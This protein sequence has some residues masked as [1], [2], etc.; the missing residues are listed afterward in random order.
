MRVSGWKSATASTASILFLAILLSAAPAPP[1]PQAAQAATHEVAL[2]LDAASSREERKN[3]EDFEE[4][5]LAGRQGVSGLAFRNP[6]KDRPFQH[7]SHEASELAFSDSC[8]SFRPFASVF[9]FCQRDD[10]R[11]VTRGGGFRRQF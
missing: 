6:N 1:R 4:N 8:V 9:G 2:T 11:N 3:I 5:V 10:T 7:N